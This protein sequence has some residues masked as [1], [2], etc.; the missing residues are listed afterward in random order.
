MRKTIEFCAALG[1]LVIMG[2]SVLAQNRKVDLEAVLESPEPTGTNIVNGVK[3]YYK[4]GFKNN[5]PD[6][7][8]AGDTI[9]YKIATSNPVVG[10]L[11]D[12][13]AM[14]ETFYVYSDSIG[15]TIPNLTEETVVDFCTKIYNPNTEITI[16]GQPV[17]I[18][19]D[20]DD[21]TNNTICA[22]IF[23]SPKEVSVLNLIKNP[24]ETLNLY[25]NPAT[26]EVKFNINLAKAEHVIVSVKDIIGREVL[27]QDFGTI[28]AGQ[29]VPMTLNL[30]SLNSG[31]YFVELNAGQHSAIGKVTIRK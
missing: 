19:Y 24:T 11:K 14:G 22:T 16:N 5:G 4:V 12:P 13:V 17:K 31:M 7:L 28:T 9:G 6:D 29:T 25:P 26:S 3:F 15:L 18:S 21:V 2:T 8:V 23:I 10:L 27:H 20:D 30:S 1:T